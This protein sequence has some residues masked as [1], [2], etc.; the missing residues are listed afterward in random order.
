MQTKLSTIFTT[1]QQV[2]I[3]TAFLAGKKKIKFL[4]PA[5]TEEHIA[6]VNML[7]KAS[8]SLMGCLPYHHH[9]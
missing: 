1:S 9:L 5:T 4:C 3:Y 2:G 8:N 6:R 7:R